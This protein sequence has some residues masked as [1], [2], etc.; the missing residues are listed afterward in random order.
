MIG[1][2]SCIRLMCESPITNTLAFCKYV[3]T[4][5]NNY[6][7]QNN[8]YAHTTNTQHTKVMLTL[9]LSAYA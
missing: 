8:Y 9:M 2:N 1:M 5:I 6:K 4:A 7:F 3:T